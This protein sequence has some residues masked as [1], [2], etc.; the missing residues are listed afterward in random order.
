MKLAAV[1]DTLEV[2]VELQIKDCDCKKGC[3]YE[4]NGYISG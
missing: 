1:M 3:N 4:C 2:V